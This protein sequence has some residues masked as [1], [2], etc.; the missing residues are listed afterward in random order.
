MEK[1]KKKKVIYTETFSIFIRTLTHH[2]I[3]IHYTHIEHNNYCLLKEV[4][5]RVHSARLANFPHTPR[6]IACTYYYN[7]VTL[8]RTIP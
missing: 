2:I 7:R 5:T 8:Y 6:L 4:I 1:K 3:Y